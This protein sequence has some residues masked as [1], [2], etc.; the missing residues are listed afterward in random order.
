MH[1]KTLTTPRYWLAKLNKYVF[2][3]SFPDAPWLS[4]SAVYLLDSWLRPTDRGI[5]W[6]LGLSTIWIALRTGNLISIESNPQW[7]ER[8]KSM[9]REKGIQEKVDLRYI[10]VD[11]YIRDSSDTHP[12]AD[13]VF[14]NSG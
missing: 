9:L 4:E 10:P 1:K 8:V 6:G 5:E 7:Y 13:I 11:K 12:Y 14:D 3:R 2:Q